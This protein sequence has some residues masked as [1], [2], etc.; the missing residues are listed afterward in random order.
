[1]KDHP[2]TIAIIPAA[3]MGR[4]MGSRKKN[5]LR[6][7]DRP[8]L[9]HTIGVFEECPLIDSIILVVPPSDIE[10][11]REEIV[12]KYGFG[13]VASVVAGGAERQDSVRNG[14][15]RASGAGITLVHD[16]ARPLV[17]FRIVEETIKAA[18]E[19]GGAVAAVAVKDTIK[20]VSAGAVVRT[21]PREALVSVQTPQAFRTDILLRAFKKA[22]EDGFL[23]T[24]ESSLVERIGERVAV[25]EGSYENIKITTVEDMAI[26]EG[27][28]KKRVSEGVI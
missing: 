6:L 1:M 27:I 12:K 11:C 8:V 5:Y 22:S 19:T 7:L 17:T 28:L 3:G 20:E 24:D 4:R 10:F 26:A 14:L 21:V 15:E 25:V 9:A 18:N 23:G 13:K 16:G 2:K